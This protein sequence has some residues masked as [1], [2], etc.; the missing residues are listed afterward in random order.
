MLLFTKDINLEDFKIDDIFQI[1]WGIDDE[2]HSCIG[3]VKGFDF[4]GSYIKYVQFQPLSSSINIGLLEIGKIPKNNPNDNF[5]SS[6]V[7]RNTPISL[8]ISKLI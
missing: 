2:Q 8:K 4:T 7:D 3:R 5:K 6:I 1:D